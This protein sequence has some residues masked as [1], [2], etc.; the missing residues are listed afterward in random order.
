MDGERSVGLYVPSSRVEPHRFAL[1]DGLPP[2]RL[3][4]YLQNGEWWLRLC[5]DSTGLLI[6]PTDQRIHR[7]GI[8]VLKLRGE[9]YNPSS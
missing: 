6:S 1:V 4:D 2:F 7:M 5:E 3:I 9:K 8:F